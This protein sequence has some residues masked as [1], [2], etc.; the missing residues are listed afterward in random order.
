MKQT[1]TIPEWHAMAQS[2]TELPMRILIHGGSM[3][4]LIRMDRDYVTIMPL[5]E[6]IRVGDIVMFSDPQKERYVLHRVWRIEESRVLTWGDNCRHPDPWLP[7]DAIW[8]RAVLIER[9]KRRIVPHPVRG[10]WM[11]RIWHPLSDTF[12]YLRGVT[13]EI[14]RRIGNILRRR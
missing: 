4:P 12:R 13:T 14:R 5:K 8:G 2:G 11:A 6:S 10:V 9:G 1:L 3:Y 7:M